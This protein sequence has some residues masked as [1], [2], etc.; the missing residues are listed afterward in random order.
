MSTFK[1]DAALVTLLSGLSTG[2]GGVV[3]VLAGKPSTTKM[4]HML[5]FASGIMIYLSFMDLLPE[6][7]DVLGTTKAN[8]SVR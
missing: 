5:S 1:I 2:L 6:S 3:V 8:T 4:G 7:V